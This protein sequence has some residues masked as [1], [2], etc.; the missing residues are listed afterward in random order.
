MYNK[1]ADSGDVV[2]QERGFSIVDTHEPGIAML[3]LSILLHMMNASSY[4]NQ[5]F[6]VAGHQG[7]RRFVSTDLHHTTSVSSYCGRDVAQ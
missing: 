3:P 2:M 5:I 6:L 1:V 7:V 4:R